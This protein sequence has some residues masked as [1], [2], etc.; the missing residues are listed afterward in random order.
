MNLRFE[1]SNLKLIKGEQ[2]YVKSI[3]HCGDGYGGPAEDG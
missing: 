1:I 2:Y 3:F